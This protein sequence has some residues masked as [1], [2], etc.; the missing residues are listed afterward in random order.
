MCQ[1][2]LNQRLQKPPKKRRRKAVPTISRP[3]LPRSMK[4]V[5]KKV[6]THAIRFGVPFNT[7]FLEFQ[8][9]IGDDVIDLFRATIFGPYLD[10]PKCNFQGQ[11]SK[12]LLLLEL[13]QSNSKVLHIR[14]ANGVI[15]KVGIKEF[16]IIT[17]LK[18]KGNTKEF[19]YPESTPCRLFQ[20]YFPGAVKSVSKNHLVQ[21]FMMGNWENNQDALQMAILYFLH[22]FILSQTGD[23]SIFV[24]EFLM[25]EDGRYQVY[26]WGQIAFT[27]L[28]DSLRQDFNLSKQL[29]RLYGLP[30]ALN[31]W[32]YEFASQLNPEIAVKERNVIPRICNLRIVA[33]KPKFE[34]LMTSIF[35]ENACSN[36]V[37]TPEELAAFDLNKDEHDPS[38][39]PTTKSVNPKIVQPN[40][41]ADFDDFSTRPPEQLLRRSSSMVLRHQLLMYTV[42]QMLKKSTMLTR[43]LRNFVILIKE[44]HSQLMLSRHKE[45]NKVDPQSSNKQPSSPIRTDSA[46]V[47]GVADFEVG[48]S[49][50]EGGQQVHVNAEI[51]HNISNRQQM[52]RVSELQLTYES[53]HVDTEANDPKK[54]SDDE[55]YQA[56]QALNE[57]NIDGD[58]ADTV[59]HN[60]RHFT[61]F[62]I[63]VDTSDSSISTTISPSTEAAIDALV[64]DLGKVP[65][66]AKPLCVYNQQ[67]LNGSHDLLSDSQLPTNIPTTVIVVRSHSKTPAPRNRVPSRII[68]P[69]YVT[70]FGSSDKGKQKLDDDVRLYFPFERCGITYQ[71]SS[72]L[73]D[74]YMQWLT[75]GLLK[76]HANKKP[77]E[78]KYRSK[79]SSF[80]FEMMNF[81]IAFPINKNWFY[82][83]SQLNKC[84]IDQHIDVIFYYLPN[85]LF[86]SHIKNTYER[87][88][89][90]NDD[91]LISTQEHIDRTSAVSVYE[92]SITNI[93]KGFEIP[94]ALPWHLVGDVY[95]R[96]I[97]DGQFHWVLL[98][99]SENDDKG[100]TSFVD[101]DGYKD[102]NSGSLLE[103]Q[104]PFMVEFAQDIMQQKSDSL[105][106]GYM[107]LHLC[108]YLGDQI[109]TSF[110]DFLPEYLRKRYGALLWSYGSEKAKGAYVSENDDPPKPKSVVTQPPEEDLVHVV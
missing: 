75:K 74:E 110:V 11:I 12:C 76:N 56:P 53:T 50:N 94:A 78:D 5:I 90:A 106:V 57:V 67:D 91:D 38:F 8:K 60:I 82:A 81:V 101:C 59:Q 102:N 107:L 37:P 80:E 41:I 71:P 48:V 103:A 17:G 31:V 96:L 15:L 42:L 32:T 43:N 72:K 16:A 105:G 9:F 47:V 1:N 23:S 85:C 73:I 98:L 95:I 62:R 79:P 69:P 19:E 51:D 84:W 77:S 55:A 29:Y 25:V 7:I 108:E 88:Y 97:R 24:N 104:V 18:C 22:T 45:N 92:R 83:M 63:T 68:Q 70:S 99:L 14:H 100:R 20:K 2:R 61:L 30:Y 58:G 89:L 52:K 44:N 6:P 27:K 39:S 21:R 109:E 49:V 40:D 34:M 13:E 28:M 35:Q 66:H 86:I 36:I 33:L 4:Y 54:V 64:S 93:I 46:N 87:Y 26:P 3:A 10:I 65:I